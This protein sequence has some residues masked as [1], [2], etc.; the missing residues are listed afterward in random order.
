MRRLA[1]RRSAR[2][3]RRHVAA[4]A[5]RRLDRRRAAGVA[6]R[7]RRHAALLRRALAELAPPSF[8]RAD[9]RLE[10]LLTRLCDNADPAK[11]AHADRRAGAAMTDTQI[12]GV[13]SYFATSGNDARRW[14]S[15]STMRFT[16]KASRPRCSSGSLALGAEQDFEYFSASVLP[17][18]F[19]ML[20]VFRDSGF[21]HALDDRGGIRRGASVAAD[22]HP[23]STPRPTSATDTRRSHRSRPFCSRAPLP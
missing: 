2:R 17:E 3:D 12:I 20:D 8:S 5:S 9:D 14:R 10:E 15:P 6:V 1:C 19:E 18:N 13:G 23:R 11:G 22:R 4:R 16:A 21:R 7:P